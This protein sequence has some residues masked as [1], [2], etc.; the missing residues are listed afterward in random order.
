MYHKIELV[1]LIFLHHSEECSEHVLFWSWEVVL[2]ITSFRSSCFSPGFL[3]WLFPAG[4]ALFPLSPFGR[5]P[6][7]GSSAA[8]G[9]WVIIGV[10][11]LPLVV[12]VF[13]SIWAL[14]IFTA[15]C[16]APSF[17]V[18]LVATPGSWSRFSLVFGSCLLNLYC[19]ASNGWIISI[20]LHYLLCGRDWVEPMLFFC[21]LSGEHFKL[22]LFEASQFIK[23]WCYSSR[24]GSSL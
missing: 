16:L 14:F 1:M 21:P 3:F 5:F 10:K 6:A 11:I 12:G 23:Q 13:S 22:L 17:F 2:A 8:G 24:A 18:P 7:G 15:C 9:S 4:R 20:K 19:P